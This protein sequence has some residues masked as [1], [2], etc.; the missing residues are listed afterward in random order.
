MPLAPVDRPMEDAAI[1]AEL[2]RLLSARR[3]FPWP[4]QALESR[5]VGRVASVDGGS[6]PVLAGHGFVVGAVRAAA[7]VVDS[8]E[9]KAATLPPPR[10]D[11]LPEGGAAGVAR[12]RVEEL[13]GVLRSP[14]RDPA[15]ALDAIREAEEWHA[16]RESLAALRSGDLLLLDGALRSEVGLLPTFLDEA[17]ALGVTLAAVA[18][19]TSATVAGAPL[20]PAALQAGRRAFPGRPWACEITPAVA[21]PGARSFAALLEAGAGRCFRIDLDERVADPHAA[22]GML[23]PLCRDPGYPGYPAP[24]AMAHNRVAFTEAETQDLAARLREGAL[25]SGVAPEAW[26]ACFEDFHEVLDRGR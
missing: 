5:P 8:G 3:D 1:V 7:L 19:R 15:R 12:R 21:E 18:K 20:L 14:P 4:F 2:A 13:G 9:P 22:L 11:L 10:L 6:A 16:G 24:L 17:W 23:L 26:D 25:R